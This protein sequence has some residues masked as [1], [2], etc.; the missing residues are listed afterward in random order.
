MTTRPVT[1]PNHSSAATPALNFHADSAS[2]GGNLSVFLSDRGGTIGG[3]ALLNFDVTHDV[4]VAGTDI[5][6]IS[7][8]ADIEL[9]NDSG[10]NIFSPF[11]GTI[12]GDATLQVSAAN[13]TLTDPA[14]SLFVA[15]NNRNG[16]LIDSNATLGFNLSGNLTTQGSAEFDIVNDQTS[17]SN[18]MAG[19]S[20]GLAA[21]LDISAANIS[22][23]TDFTAL[24][25]NHRGAGAPGP[26]AGSIGTDATLN[27]GAGSFTTGGAF[28]VSIYNRDNGTGSGTGGSIGGNAI[29]NFNVTNGL[30]I[31]GDGDFL[32][33]NE[34]LVAG[35]PGGS[36]GGDAMI[37]VS[38]ASISTGGAFDAEIDNFS[39]GSNAGIIGGGT[40]GGGAMIDVTAA[41]ITANSLTAQID[42]TGGSI[43]ASTE[44]GA[45]INMNVSGTASVTNDATVAIYG[46]DGAGSAAINI[47]GGSYNVGGTFLTYIDGNGRS[48]SLMPARTR[49]CSK[50]ACSAR[51]ACSMSA[52]AFSR[53]IP[54]LK[55]YASGSNGTLNFLSNVT[56]GGGALTKI[57]AANTI[58]I[59]DNVV[60]TIGGSTMVDVYTNNANYTG[61]G[62]NGTRTGTFAGAGAN[63]PQPLATRRRLVR[64]RPRALP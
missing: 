21:T 33:L 48:H 26:G 57:L 35:S 15:I 34:S 64:P 10:T 29:I 7:D 62:G 12:H 31:G 45:T 32:I 30:Q 53:L 51:T 49:M 11:G 27:I 60:V 54:T 38:A 43:G 4:T 25:L 13:F 47:N 2:I 40:I 42:N 1:P 19:G 36:I 8:A 58:N 41:N 23:G 61:F 28:D 46:S 5:P 56:L 20:I 59:F 16:G 24:I 37:N 14:G 50:R 17:F 22:I 18:G 63:N 6:N 3:N 55:L 44:A 9:L 52:A 39:G